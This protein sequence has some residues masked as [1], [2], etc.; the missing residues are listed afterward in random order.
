[1]RLPGQDHERIG[2]HQFGEIAQLLQLPGFRRRQA[3]FA[4]YR[5]GKEQGFARG[6]RQVGC[7][8]TDHQH[9]IEAAQMGA[10]QGQHDYPSI[11][12]QR[13]ERR[14]LHLQ[15]DAGAPFGK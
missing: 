11:A 8:R 2:R 9:R 15:T 12:A 1:M 10:V 14:R 6:R 13:P 3:E 4:P 5:V 7:I